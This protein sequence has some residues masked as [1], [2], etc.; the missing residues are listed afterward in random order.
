MLPLFLAASA[1]ANAVILG[2]LARRL[3]GV[4]VGWPRTIV[5]S[6]VVVQSGGAA[7][8]ALAD[9]LDLPGATPGEPVNA[10]SGLVLTL[11]IAWA[12]ALGLAALVV[13]EAI[14]PTG[15]IP[16]PV[17]MVR[18]WSARRRRARRYTQIVGIAARHGLGGF[19]RGR[20]R[21]SPTESSTSVARRLRDALADGG[22]TFVK[23]GQMLATRPDVI[24]AD[25]AAELAT[26]QT[27]VPPAPWS[28][29]EPVLAAELGRPWSEVFASVDRQ[30]LAAASVAQVHA[31]TLPDGTQVVVKVQRPGAR[32]QVTADLDIVLRLASWLQRSTVWGRA[33]GVRGLAEGFA[34]SLEEELDYTV[35]LA[36]T[37]TI[38][39]ALD[40][41]DVT[42]VTVPR[43]Y[44]AWSGPR[45]LVMERLSGRPVSESGDELARLDGATRRA[46]ADDLLHVILRQVLVDGTFHADLHQGNVFLDDRGL[47]QLLDFG[48][49]GRL[50][51]TAS[52]SLGVFLHAVDRNDNVAAADAL[53]DVLV[54]PERL[55]DRAFGREL[56]EVIS[57]YRGGFGSAGSSGMFTALMT[58]ILRHHFGV[59][60]QV[61]AALRALGALEGTLATIAP[62]HDLVDSARRHGRAL[63][64]EQF[65]PSEVRATLE[66]QLLTLAPMLQRLPRR[67]A[68]ITDQIEDGRLSVGVRILADP[69]DRAFVD[70]VIRQLVITVLASAC[71]IC[72]VVLFVADRG[73][74]LVGE[75][76]LF[77]FLGGTL[78]FFAFVLAAR[79][80]VR[81]FRP[82]R[83]E[84]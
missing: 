63:L 75:V 72:G 84:P 12:F 43:V 69:R 32:A 83:I 33:L 49:V 10:G 15:T 47:L 4:P 3:L 77:A 18:T 11:A 34:T 65:M 46:L 62:D 20:S 70:D 52:R 66:D 51:A 28:E 42:S 19:L 78:F 53:I 67:L 61:A 37:T 58:I 14:V 7:I 22:V 40:R 23:L 79:A 71:A 38:G 13:L 44:A 68:A 36:N 60:P 80:L 9:T 45:L 41:G 8:T 29:I 50:D 48:S 57:R 82:V 59:P 64:G 35:E 81:V 73:P 6:L 31:A 21:L 54:R 25:A 5:V 26:L 16:S 27:Q 2:I 30:P 74:L 56:G 24:G 39:A 76:R 1:L 17:A 55:D